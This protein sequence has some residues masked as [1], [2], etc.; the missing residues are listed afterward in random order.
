MKRIVRRVQSLNE[1]A[2][3]LTAA[4]GQFPE[5]VAE[6]R[7]AVTAT[8]DQLQTLKSDIQI[9][10]SGLTVDDDSDM[11]AA[12]AEIAENASLLEE[13]GFLLDGLDIE[14]S[15][16]QRVLIQLVRF[17][18]V[19]AS[20]IQKLIWDHQNH[21]T[22][23]AVLTSILKA[24]SMADN[25]EISDLVYHKLVIAIGPV[26]S[27]RLCWRSAEPSTASASTAW[28]SGPSTTF[29]A[30]TSFFEPAQATELVPPAST[31]AACPAPP[32]A[33]IE[34]SANEWNEDTAPDPHLRTA[35]TSIDDSPVPQ[36]DLEIPGHHDGFISE[37]AASAS[38]FD[39][40]PPHPSPEP[41]DPL[42]RF[43]VMPNLA[44]NG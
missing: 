26:P 4:V 17:E 25:V 38:A 16:V 20:D 34:S 40:A 18:D 36:E 29:A 22:L 28:P 24:K 21:G 37:P 43:K 35:T 32:P 30:G 6:L 19:E 23:N 8:S 12:L 15:P 3:E 5:R 27:V 1:R 10:A 31:V 39:P 9:S 2:A 11:S 33:S 41:A 14:V 13:A 7:G 44:R 42:A